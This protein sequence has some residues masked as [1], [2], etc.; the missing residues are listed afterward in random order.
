MSVRLFRDSQQ[1]LIAELE[2]I[3]GDGHAGIETPANL[4]TMLPFARVPRLGG[5]RTQLNDAAS[6]TVDLV[7]G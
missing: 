5:P 7:A 3:V 4:A 1:L 2:T 6:A